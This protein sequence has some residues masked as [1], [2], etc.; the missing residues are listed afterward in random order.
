MLSN[1]QNNNELL[2]IPIRFSDG[3]IMNA[4]VCPPRHP[5]PLSKI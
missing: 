2:I 3:D 1:K 4:S 5:K